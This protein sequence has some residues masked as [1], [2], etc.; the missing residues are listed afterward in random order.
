MEIPQA[1]PEQPQQEQAAPSF[2]VC[3]APQP[4]GSFTVSKE[5]MG[6]EM[7]EGAEGQEPQGQPAKSVDEALQMAKQMLTGGDQAQAQR[8][9]IAAQVYGGQQ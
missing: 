2:Q 7:D 8:A 1:V 3:I 6:Q 5:P 4:D 9:D